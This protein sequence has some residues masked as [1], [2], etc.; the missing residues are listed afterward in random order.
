MGLTKVSTDGFKDDSVTTDKLEADSVTGAK[1]ADDAV[2]AEHIED[3][4]SH[5][6]LLDNSQAQFGTGTDLIIKHDGTNSRIE[7]TTGLLLLQ[8]ADVRITNA[9]ADETCLKAVAD[10]SVELYHNNELKLVTQAD[11]V[12]VQ[13]TSAVSAYLRIA[14]SAGTEGSLYG[15]ANTLGF[16]D[17]Q[18]HYM[19]KGVKDGAVELYHDNSKKFETTSYGTRTTGYHTQST[20]IGFQ[21]DAADWTSSQP[22]MHNMSLQ[23]DSGDL[24]NSTGVFTCPVAGKYLCSASVQAH[25]TNN[26]SGAS[27]TFYNVLWQK[28]SSNYH[29]EMVGTLATDASAQGVNDVNGKHETITATVIMDCA[30]NDTIRAHSNHGYR[31]NTQNIISVYLLG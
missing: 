3:L 9:A 6:K 25:R 29:I 30:A 26:S 11:G 1:I 7:N 16:L 31:H 27:S 24:V 2:G 18:N 5:I 14:T 20:A 19:L 21:G 17:G 28:N 12:A 22:N 8:G 10:G 4:D 13:D 15:T 23:W